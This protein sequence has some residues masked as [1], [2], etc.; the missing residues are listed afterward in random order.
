MAPVA[1]AVERGEALDSYAVGTAGMPD[2]DALGGLGVAVIFHDLWEKR[3]RTEF[4][5]YVVWAVSD[6]PPLKV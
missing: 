6:H 2:G 3:T 4:N 1:I 5:S